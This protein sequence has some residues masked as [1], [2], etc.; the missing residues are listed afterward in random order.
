M[1]ATNY[2][3]DSLDKGP[4]NA[5]GQLLSH[6]FNRIHDSSLKPKALDT[7]MSTSIYYK[8]P[9]VIRKYDLQNIV[10]ILICLFYYIISDAICNSDNIEFI[11]N[12][13]HTLYMFHIYIGI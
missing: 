10:S 12:A 8:I 11:N 4:F 5:V 7:N 13:Y 1:Y 3:N 9:L 6:Q 2:P